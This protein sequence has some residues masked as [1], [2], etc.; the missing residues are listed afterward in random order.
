MPALGLR[1]LI[2][3]ADESCDAKLEGWRQ[4]TLIITFAPTDTPTQTARVAL[5]TIDLAPDYPALSQAYAAWKAKHPAVILD[6]ELEE[7][8]E[9][10]PVRARFGPGN[11]LN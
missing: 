4:A 10:A 2:E 5:Q 6:L 9:L 8:E 1:D 11:W 7:S 3:D